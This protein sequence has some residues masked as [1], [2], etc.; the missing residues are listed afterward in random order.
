MPYSNNGYTDW[1]LPASWELNTLYNNAYMINKILENDGDGNTNGLSFKSYWSSTE[2]NEVNSW[3]HDFST[4]SQ[5][6]ID[7]TNMLC[8][9]AIRSF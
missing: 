1:Y 2:N 8:I 7:K 3:K 9:R 5:N 6:N 4:G